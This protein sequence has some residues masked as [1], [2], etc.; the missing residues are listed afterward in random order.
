MTTIDEI[1]SNLMLLYLSEEDKNKLNNLKEKLNKYLLLKEYFIKKNNIEFFR[2]YESDVI[3]RNHERDYLKSEIE[4]KIIYLIN[5]FRHEIF[6]LMYKFN[7]RFNDK[8]EFEHL[9]EID[10]DL[11]DILK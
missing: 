8:F 1:K 10:N 9:A 4:F 7:K 11:K 5:H 6:I 3:N 2:H